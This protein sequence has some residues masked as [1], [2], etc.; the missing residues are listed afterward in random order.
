MGNRPTIAYQPALDG[1]RAF[2]VIAVLL[3]HAGIPG[4]DGGYLG[5]SVFFTLS[6]FLITSLL[7]DEWNIRAAT[8]DRRLDLGRFYVRRLK[9]L[10]PAA[11]STLLA[12]VVLRLVVLSSAAPV[13]RYQGF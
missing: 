10:M 7:V 5:V 4:F 12:V 1:V 2:A 3:F 6:G 11:M 8:D 9:R 13:F